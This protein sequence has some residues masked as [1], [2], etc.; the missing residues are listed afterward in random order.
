MHATCPRCGGRAALEARVDLRNG[1]NRPLDRRGVYSCVPCGRL[2]D[3]SEVID[4]G[5][6]G[7][8]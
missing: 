3:S 5:D 8:G 7:E 1:T 6:D 2:F 4:Q